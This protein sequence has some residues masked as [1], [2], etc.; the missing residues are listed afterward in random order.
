M[1]QAAF[2]GDSAMSNCCQ[3]EPRHSSATDRRPI[4]NSHVFL[5]PTEWSFKRG[6]LA[7]TNESRRWALSDVLQDPGGEATFCRVFSQSHD[8]PQ[9]SMGEDT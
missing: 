7:F 1:G 5:L 2:C 9:L 6:R 3:V 4:R 8:V